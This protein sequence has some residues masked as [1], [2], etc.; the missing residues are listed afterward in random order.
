VEWFCIPLFDKAMKKGKGAKQNSYTESHVA[1]VD[2]VEGGSEFFPKWESV[3]EME[4]PLP[5][6]CIGI[7]NLAENL[8]VIQGAQQLRGKILSRKELARGGRLLLL[9]LSP[10][11]SS[12]F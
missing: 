9:L 3:P 1:G 10:W 12:A 8:E 7:R 2:C 11:L 6:R 5:P 4:Y